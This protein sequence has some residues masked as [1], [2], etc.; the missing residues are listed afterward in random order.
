[1]TMEISFQ[2]E[3][4][5]ILGNSI[6]SFYQ[7]LMKDLN[8]YIK[9]KKCKSKKIKIYFKTHQANLKSLVEGLIRI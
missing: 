6:L 2:L 5:K 3:I 9:S 1:M 8:N 7:E 4:K